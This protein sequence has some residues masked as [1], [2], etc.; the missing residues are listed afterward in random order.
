[1]SKDNW[2]A[3]IENIEQMER[4]GLAQLTDDES[5]LDQCSHHVCLRVS[6]EALARI[7]DAWVD[8]TAFGECSECGE[9]IFFRNNAPKNA[10]RI[11]YDCAGDLLSAD[12]N[13]ILISRKSAVDEIKGFIKKKEQH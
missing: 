13:P 2:K 6:P 10:V 8:Q 7:P 11:C 5:V 4:D 3:G 9:K 1:M 12:E